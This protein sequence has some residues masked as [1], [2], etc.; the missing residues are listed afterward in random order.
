M[1]KKIISLVEDDA[2]VLKKPHGG[3][4]PSPGKP[5]LDPA[6]KEAKASKEAMD[7]A[8]PAASSAAGDTDL[9][10]SGAGD[11]NAA[12]NGDSE[13][14]LAMIK[15]IICEFLGDGEEPTDDLVHTTKEMVQAAVESGMSKEDAAKHAGA[16][17]KMAKIMG[18]KHAKDAP[19]D[20]AAK[21]DVA[22]AVVP[23]KK[24]SGDEKA[25]MDSKD[26]KEESA[27]VAKESDKQVIARLTG[28]ISALRESIRKVDLATHL[29]KVCRESGLS[30]PVTKAFRELVKTAK[31]ADEISATWKTFKSAIDGVKE[32]SRASLT[33]SGFG[34]TIPE[35]VTVNPG[36]KESGSDSIKS[37]GF[38]DCVS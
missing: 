27:A 37:N 30:V 9:A 20:D 14:D 36:S 5:G 21:A 12:A 38:S 23:E 26:K 24:E 3:E 29:D 2:T 32:S 1:T 11:G 16:G 33:E 6:A 15:Q 31:S 10:T 8:L 13:T 34:F 25:A 19:K 22:A 28:E 18:N 7:E 4:A 17:L 35:K